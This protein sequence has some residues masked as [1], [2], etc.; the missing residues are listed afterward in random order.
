MF[1]IFSSL[2]FCSFSPSLVN[3]KMNREVYVCVFNF[4]VVVLFS[5]DSFSVFI[6]GNEEAG[7][8]CRVDFVCKDSLC[9][10]KFLCITRIAVTSAKLL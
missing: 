3:L 1:E 5:F 7:S 8:E 9:Y 10:S 2:S 6:E 4:E